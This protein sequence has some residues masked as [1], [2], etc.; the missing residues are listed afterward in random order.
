MVFGF[1]L[2]DSEIGAGEPGIEPAAHPV[3]DLA[4]GFEF[5]VQRAD[6]SE[7]DGA[8]AA[9]PPE[10]IPSSLTLV[11]VMRL[12]LPGRYLGAFIFQSNRR[13]VSSGILRHSSRPRRLSHAIFS[14]I[15]GSIRQL[16]CGMNMPGKRHTASLTS[17]VGPLSIRPESTNRQPVK[18]SSAG[19]P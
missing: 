15:L 3:G 18:P 17:A 14:A 19:C 5:R 6:Q 16:A 11:T 13:D 4:V 8:F 2:G 9:G 12:V 7:G 10:G 1:Q